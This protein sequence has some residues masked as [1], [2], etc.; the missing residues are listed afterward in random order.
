MRWLISSAR[1]RTGK[2]MADKLA[3]ELLDAFHGQGATVKK[4]DDTAPHGRR[5]QGVRALSLVD[6]RRRQWAARCARRGPL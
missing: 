2:T 3:G 1:N 4:R 5:E 6:T